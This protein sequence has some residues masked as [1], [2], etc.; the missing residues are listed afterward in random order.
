MP[1]YEF[2]CA[3]D[4][5]FQD[6]R[7]LGDTKPPP[8]PTC[9]GVMTRKYSLFQPKMD[10]QPHFNAAVG[11]YVNGKNDLNDAFKTLSEERT[12]ATGIE[13]RYVA[14]DPREA[15]TEL[16]VTDEGLDATY[17]KMRDDGMS[18]A[19]TQWL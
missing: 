8:C 11:R 16:G 2:K 1:I 13:H 6:W 17:A 9:S 4:G 7:E 5:V 3:K 18:E 10:M 19:K 14:V 15:K 12:E